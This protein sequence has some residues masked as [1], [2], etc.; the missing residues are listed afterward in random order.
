MPLTDVNKLPPNYASLFIACQ[1]GL[2]YPTPPHQGDQS[3]FG[4]LLPP[5]LAHVPDM[6]KSSAQIRTELVIFYNELES[7]CPLLP[8]PSGN[9]PHP[10]W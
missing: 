9:Q 3:I 4:T 6:V 8:G 10:E 2:D 1:G 5:I 7:N